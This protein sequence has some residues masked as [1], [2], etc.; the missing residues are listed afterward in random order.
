MPQTKATFESFFYG[1]AVTD[2][3]LPIEDKESS[4]TSNSDIF[5]GKL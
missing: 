4:P 2:E 5:S 1:Q 3:K